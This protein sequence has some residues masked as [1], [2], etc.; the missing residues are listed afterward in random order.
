MP[1]HNIGVV[2]SVDERLG[3]ESYVFNYD[4]PSSLTTDAEHIQWCRKFVPSPLPVNL[5]IIRRAIKQREDGGY[6][7][8]LHFEGHEDPD[9]ADGEEFS[10]DGST[11]KERIETHANLPL[12]IELYEGEVKPNGVTFPIHL[13]ADSELNLDSEGDM[14][15]KNPLYG[16]TSF[17]S[18]GIVWTRSWVANRF[19]QEAANMLG[20]IDQ[21][22]IGPRGETPPKLHGARNWL[23]MRFNAEWRGNVWKCRMSWVLSGRDGWN[24]DIYRRR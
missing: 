15:P 22:P 24:P 20:T 4:S 3:I 14:L 16:V 10:L 7:A 23:V 13:S 17:Y 19:P 6:I 1:Q 12:L 5:P 9:N 11:A 8:E 2:G 21:P 18:P